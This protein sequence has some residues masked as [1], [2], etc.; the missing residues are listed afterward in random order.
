MWILYTWISLSALKEKGGLEDYENFNVALGV[1][2]PNPL[3]DDTAE[4]SEDETELCYTQVHFPAKPGCQ[5]GSGTCN[6]EETQYS[7]LQFW[8]NEEQV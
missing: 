1:Q 7:K 2:T 5:R 8:V 3:N 6:E 4:T